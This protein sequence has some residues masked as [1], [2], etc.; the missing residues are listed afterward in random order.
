MIRKTLLVMALG[1]VAAP[2][3]AVIASTAVN[4]SRPAD[5][6]GAVEIYNVAGSVHV[7]GWDKA[8]VE[9]T[10]SAGK[11]V[12]RVE[13]SGGGGHT[14]VRV[15]LRASHSWNSEGEAN[16][17]VHVPAGSSLSCNTVSADVK[18][19]AVRGEATLKTVSGNIDAEV[20]GDVSAHAVSGTVHVRAPAAKSIEIDTVSGNAEVSGGGGELQVTTVSG[21]AKVKLA[22]T[23]RARFQTVSGTMS[24]ALSLSSDARLDAQSVSGDVRLDFPA[25]PAADFDMQTFSG[26]IHNC[27]GPK[28]VES[29]H[30]S[31][32]SLN[33]KN[34]EGSARVRVNTHSG[35]IEICTK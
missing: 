24:A 4:E 19:G 14:S 27:F 1:S 7:Q 29:H 23:T 17:T 25:P 15:V 32:S 2:W 34:G 22:T 6:Q 12:E 16:L 11:D 28:P 30:G 31:G 13:V 21:D 3:A 10:G 18:V 35:S 33:F 26:D 5:A 20:G 8:E 9:V